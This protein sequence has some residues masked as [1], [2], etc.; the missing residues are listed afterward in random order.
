MQSLSV[1]IALVVSTLTAALA[2]FISHTDADSA[3]PRV[4]A[5]NGWS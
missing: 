4:I 1:R 5:D 2:L 3:T